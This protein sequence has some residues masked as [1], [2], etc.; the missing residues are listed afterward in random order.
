MHPTS[1]VYGYG[2]SHI[3][4]GATGSHV[5]GS[6]VSHVTG[7]DVSHMT[8]SDP[9]R[10]YVLRTCN[11]KLRNIRPS[12]AFWPEVTKS[13][14][15]NRLCPEVVLTGSRFCACPAFPRVFFLVVV[16]WVPDMTKGHLTPFGVPLGVRNRKL[17]NIRSDWRS[18]DPF[19]SVHG[20]FSATSASNYPRKPRILYLVT[21]TSLGYLPLLFSYSV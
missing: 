19:G 15:R 13:R 8:R 7:S 16:S 17:R 1:E 14:D 2:H 20:V 10:K 21:G 6:D 5:T 12:R 18:R 4:G 11:L 9:V 3:W